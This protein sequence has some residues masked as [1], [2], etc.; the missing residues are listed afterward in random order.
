[1]PVSSIAFF[2][3]WL[4]D[5]PPGAARAPVRVKAPG[6]EEGQHV[7]GCDEVLLAQDAGEGAVHVAVRAH[8]PHRLGLRDAA[9]VEEA[10]LRAAQRVARRRALDGAN[11]RRAAA[12]EKEK[13][14]AP[15]M[16][17][18]LRGADSTV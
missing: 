15:N 5:V 12:Q 2:L 1:M 6:A 16:P 18:L 10:R 4:I 11:R 8:I 9:A 13:A 7:D 3:R 17:R 14:A